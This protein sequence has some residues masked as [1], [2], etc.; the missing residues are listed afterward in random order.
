MRCKLC[1]QTF[2]FVGVLVG[3]CTFLWKLIFLWPRAFNAA[4]GV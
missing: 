2:G 3:E 1:K 4:H